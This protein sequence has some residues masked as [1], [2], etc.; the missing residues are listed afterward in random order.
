MRE[1]VTRERLVATCA[2]W[3]RLVLAAAI[4]ALVLA[5]FA[6]GIGNDA[7]SRCFGTVAWFLAI[8]AVTA[9]L[10]AEYVPGEP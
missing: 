6:T 9:G 4:A 3:W 8:V 7:L 10:I 5:A 2:A 1:L